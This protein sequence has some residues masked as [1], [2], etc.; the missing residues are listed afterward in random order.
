MAR[1][2]SH[3]ASP[4]R[5]TALH[6]ASIVGGTVLMALASRVAIPLPWSPVPITGQTFAIP[7]LVALL[8]TRGAVASLLLYLAEG[9]AGLP[10]FAPVADGTFGIARLFGPSGGYLIA[11]PVAAYVTGALFDLGLRRSYLGRL[12]AILAGTAVVFAGGATWLAHFLGAE[13]A[14]ALGVAPF[15]I[16]DALK[17]LGAAALVPWLRPRS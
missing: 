5:T 12:A 1:S 9:S 6:I 3:A 8:G 2:T 16:G 15:L 17:S 11:F 10:V 7:I 13:R 4:P 14:F